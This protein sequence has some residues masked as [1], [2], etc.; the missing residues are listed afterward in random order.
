MTESQYLS[1]CNS[2]KC[3]KR[4][5]CVH[6]WFLSS[7]LSPRDLPVFCKWWNWLCFWSGL[8][9]AGGDG[10]WG[11][12]W[13]GE[14]KR[15]ASIHPPSLPDPSVFFALQRPYDIHASNSVES[16]IQLFSTI[17]VQYSPAWPKDLVSLLRKVRSASL[18]VVRIICVGVDAV[19]SGRAEAILINIGVKIIR[20]SLLRWD[21]HPSCPSSNLLSTYSSDMSKKKVRWRVRI[22]WAPHCAAAV[23]ICLL[24]IS[25]HEEVLPC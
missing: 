17:S 3:C 25:G 5:L 1:P 19:V 14:W 8:V 24:L 22:K 2:R 12:P 9:V 10:L 11:S 16:L 21:I 15:P 7:A 18:S 23:K 4:L 6:E 13:M 20:L